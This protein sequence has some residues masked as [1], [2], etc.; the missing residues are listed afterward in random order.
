LARTGL[1]FTRI[2]EGAQ[3]GVLTQTQPGQTE[4]GIPYNVPSRWVPVEG[5]RLGSVRRRSC[6]GE[7]VYGVVRSVL[8][9]PLICIIAVPFVCCSVKLP[10]SRLTSF[11]PVSFHSPLHRGGGRGGRVALFVAGGSR[12]QNNF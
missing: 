12:N 11:L 9:I 8:C 2:R 1:I 10:L 5:A 7:W 3:P 6:L 4:P